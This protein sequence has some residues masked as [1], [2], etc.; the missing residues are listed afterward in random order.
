MKLKECFIHLAS[1]KGG[2]MR[3]RCLFL[4]VCLT[5]CG[6][7][8]WADECPVEFDK[9]AQVFEDFSF[10]TGWLPEDG[11]I[12]VRI[13]VELGDTF[14]ASLPGAAMR[15]SGEV[16]FDG[17]EDG[18]SYL[19]NV[20]P[21]VQC[22]LK[23][24]LNVPGVGPVQ[25][26]GE[27]PSAPN[28]DWRFDDQTSYTPFL[29]PG[30]ADRP[31]SVSDDVPQQRLIEQDLGALIPVP[32]ISGGLAIDVAGVMQSS[33]S[34]EEISLGQETITE[35]GQSVVVGTDDYSGSSIYQATFQASG[36][37]SF[38][39]TVFIEILFEEY[40]LAEFEI[41]VEIPAVEDLWEFD[42][43]DVTLSGDSPDGGDPDGGTP[44]GSGTSDQDQ[45]AGDGGCSCGEQPSGT[46]LV[47]LFLL[48]LVSLRARKT[49]VGIRR[50][51]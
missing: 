1:E 19:M 12:Q 29:L 18:G 14:A 2:F 24:D 36:T 13:I 49:S 28:F 21:E 10:D 4:S 42:P 7:Q 48:C 37:L 16:H 23:V 30:S 33:L 38:Y 34:G 11:S 20:G 5:L 27:I 9:T 50:I 17:E 32:G 45:P 8:A 25:W 31:A 3:I 46:G 51:R 41:P 6:F 44:D 43:Q 26:E 22:L 35:E 47:A 40:E 15:E 39:P